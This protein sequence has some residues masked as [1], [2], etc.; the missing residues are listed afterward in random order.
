MGL[1][2]DDHDAPLTRALGAEI[3]NARTARGWT[4]A[5]LAA[6]L[7]SETKESTLASWE[8]GRYPVTVVRY[9]ELCSILDVSPPELLTLALQQLE[10]DLQRK[11]LQ[12]GRQD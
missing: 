11:R 12:V 3:R 4:R 7:R 5:E 2:E 1:A 6:R 10:I 8:R 9:V